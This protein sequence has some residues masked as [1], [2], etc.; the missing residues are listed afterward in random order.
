MLVYQKDDASQQEEHVKEA[1]DVFTDEIESWRVGFRKFT[2]P[3]LFRGMSAT[4]V[5]YVN[6]VLSQMNPAFVLHPVGHFIQMEY[7][8]FIFW[9]HP[10][11]YGEQYARYSCD[12]A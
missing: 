7:G 12:F 2:K 9:I 6:N 10:S 1:V 11:Y 5:K 3:I 8:D 4:T